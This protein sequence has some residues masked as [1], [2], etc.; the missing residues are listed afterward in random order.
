MKTSQPLSNLKE[1]SAN[2]RAS[3]Q[4]ISR[5]VKDGRSSVKGLLFSVF[6][7]YFFSL[8]VVPIIRGDFH[9][10]RQPLREADL[11]TD[12]EKKIRNEHREQQT[13]S[14]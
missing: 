3:E 11:A 13:C 12:K 10:F 9:D 14:S 2:H 7:S 6:I 4:R 1:L 8:S 5:L